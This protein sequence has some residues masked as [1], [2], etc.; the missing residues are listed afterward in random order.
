L[1]DHYAELYRKP[2]FEV[3]YALDI[4]AEMIENKTFKPRPLEM[5]VSIRDAC[6]LRDIK[7]LPRD[8]VRSTGARINEL[9]DGKHTCCGGPAGLKPNF[10]EVSAE[11]AMLSV[12][13]YKKR[14]DALISYC[15]F[16]KHHIGGVCSSTG[17]ELDMRDVSVLLAESVLGKDSSL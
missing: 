14:S 5:T 1:R 10:P 6:P 3:V 7:H 2:G 13:D 17:E 15:P 16:C 4:F 12:K 9:F 11:I 8:I